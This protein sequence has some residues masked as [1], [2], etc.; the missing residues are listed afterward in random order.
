MLERADGSSVDPG[1]SRSFSI[2]FVADVVANPTT[3]SIPSYNTY[4]LRL[5]TE[6]TANTH[7]IQHG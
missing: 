6:S 3:K 2:H 1:I 7:I 4:L 5:K